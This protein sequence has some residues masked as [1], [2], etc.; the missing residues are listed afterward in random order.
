MIWSRERGR[1]KIIEKIEKN[2]S[3]SKRTK[4]YFQDNFSWFAYTEAGEALT[5]VSKNT[6]LKK[7]TMLLVRIE[8][9]RGWRSLFV[10]GGL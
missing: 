4:F 7:K 5:I 9:D 6:A 10:G 8:D 2:A 1:K 3:Y